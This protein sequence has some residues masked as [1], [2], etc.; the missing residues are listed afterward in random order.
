ME[1]AVETKRVQILVHPQERLLV[2]VVGVLGR[3]KQIQRQPQNIL[4]VQAHQLL[5]GA[6]IALLSRPNQFGFVHPDGRVGHSN[7]QH[8]GRRAVNEKVTPTGGRAGLA[9]QFDFDFLVWRVQLDDP[10]SADLAGAGGLRIAR[11]SPCR[12]ASIWLITLRLAT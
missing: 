4:I 12:P 9:G 5:K 11:I 6:L 8:Y 1:A 3:P 2:N 10:E 7:L